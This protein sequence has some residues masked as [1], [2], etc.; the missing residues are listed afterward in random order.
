MVAVLITQTQQPPLSGHTLEMVEGMEAVLL[1]LQG[2]SALAV[3]LGGI[4]ARGEQGLAQSILQD[5]LALVAVVA[6]AG[7]LIIQPLTGAVRA[8]AVSAYLDK[9]QM[10]PVVEFHQIAV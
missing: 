9:D 2:E 5:Q 3:E 10:V 1:A 8:E 6:E 7:H 4:Q